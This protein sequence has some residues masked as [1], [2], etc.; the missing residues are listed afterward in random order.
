MEGRR[1]TWCRVWPTAPANSDQHA[2]Q[3]WMQA[4]GQRLLSFSNLNK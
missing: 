1:P 3:V 4:Y 2:Y